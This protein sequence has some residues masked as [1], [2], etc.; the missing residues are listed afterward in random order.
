MVKIEEDI[1]FIKKKLSNENFMSK[2]PQ[3]VVEENKNKYNDYLD[4]LKSISNNIS[5]LNQWR[6][7]DE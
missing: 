4:K 3:A 5:K 6:K 2:A 1:E 7:S